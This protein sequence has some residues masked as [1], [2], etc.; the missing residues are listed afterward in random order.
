MAIE[1][2]P[3][4][5]SSL[6]Y[7]HLDRMSDSLKRGIEVGEI[8]NATFLMSYYL[9][10]LHLESLLNTRVTGPYWEKIREYKEDLPSFKLAWSGNLS[11]NIK[12]LESVSKWFQVLLIVANE[13]NFIT[14][15]PQT[16]VASIDE[17]EGEDEDE[18]GA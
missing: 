11:E 5:Y 15:S 2:T 7:R 6:I 3:M 4:N 14:I 10:V 17:E 16:Y 8:K 9:F 12:F 18:N 13:Y 1:R